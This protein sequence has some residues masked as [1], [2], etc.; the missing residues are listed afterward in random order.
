MGYAY[1]TAYRPR[2]AYGNTVENSVYICQ[3]MVGRGG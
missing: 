2:A 3:E 1:A